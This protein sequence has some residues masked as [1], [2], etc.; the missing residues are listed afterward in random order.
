MPEIHQQNECVHYFTSIRIHFRAAIGGQ[1]VRARWSHCD[2]SSRAKEPVD[3][4][5]ARARETTRNRL[6]GTADSAPWSWLCVRVLSLFA[7]FLHEV[8]S[9]C[10]SQAAPRTLWCVCLLI[11][12]QPSRHD[13]PPARSEPRAG[14]Y[15]G[16]NRG[17]LGDLCA[18]YLLG[19]G[20][21]W[22]SWDAV[23]ARV[24]RE[25]RNQSTDRQSS[26]LR[27]TNTQPPGCLVLRWPTVDGWTRFAPFGARAPVSPSAGLCEPI[28]VCL[29][30]WCS[31]EVL[32]ASEP[33]PSA[34][35][36][37]W[38]Q[39]RRVSPRFGC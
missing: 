29:L 25:S 18:V 8:R 19:P 33:F 39:I 37:R 3:R 30:K 26:A 32:V 13:Q 31:S 5:S 14:R 24:V 28:P 35:V 21:P 7:R 2:G 34:P 16:N 6:A 11:L 36:T 9:G 12:F 1:H 4:Q 17:D 22:R 20:A 38:F 23:P 10:A 27:R 15:A